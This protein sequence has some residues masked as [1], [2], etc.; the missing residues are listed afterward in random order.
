MK[1]YTSKNETSKYTVIDKM[2]LN[3]NIQIGES[4]Y[5][6]KDEIVSF[7]LTKSTFWVAFINDM[8]FGP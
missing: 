5:T 4:K 1:D 3:I 8:Y 7:N 6:T 2:G